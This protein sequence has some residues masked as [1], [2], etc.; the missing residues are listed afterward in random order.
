MR[1]ERFFDY[2]IN[3]SISSRENIPVFKD[4]NSTA[5]SI[6]RINSLYLMTDKLK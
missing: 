1:T 6:T 4:F 3:I 2:S 5:K